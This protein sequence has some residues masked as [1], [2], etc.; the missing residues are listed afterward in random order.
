MTWA[1]ANEDATRMG[2]GMTTTGHYLNVGYGEG[3]FVSAEHTTTRVQ[4]RRRDVCTEMEN[5]KKIRI[6]KEQKTA[7]QYRKKPKSMSLIPVAT[8]TDHSFRICGW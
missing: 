3:R 5:N 8:R 4:R 7:T 6:Q 1:V 2:E